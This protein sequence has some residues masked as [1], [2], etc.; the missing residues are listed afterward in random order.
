M[1]FFRLLLVSGPPE[2]VKAAAQGHAEQL[3]RLRNE[4]RLRLAGTFANGDGYC[5]ILDVADRLEA[6]NLTR[7]SPLVERGLVSWILRE[8]TEEEHAD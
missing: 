2:D 1:K 6:E 5:E 8:W 3:D 7:Q 4:G